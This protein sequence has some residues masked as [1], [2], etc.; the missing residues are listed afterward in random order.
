M[1]KGD[2]SKEALH[3]AYNGTWTLF[4]VAHYQGNGDQN[5]WDHLT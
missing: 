3:M 5:Q 4:S 2:F 1:D